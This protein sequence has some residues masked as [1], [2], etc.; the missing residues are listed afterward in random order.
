M[1]TT[2][3]SLLFR[4]IYSLKFQRVCPSEEAAFTTLGSIAL[5]G[6]R[7]AI[8]QLGETFLVIGLGLLG[9]IAVQLLRACGCNVIG[10]DLDESLTG[11]IQTYGATGVPISQSAARACLDF[12]QGRGVDGVII[13]AGTSS[14]DPIELAGDVT[15]EKGRVVVVGAVGMNVPREPYFKKEINLCI[16][17]SYGPGR[18]DPNYE[19]KGNDYPLGYVRF[20]EQRNMESFL[21]LVADNKINISG[22]I[23]H[24]FPLEEAAKAYQLIEGEKVEPYLGIVVQYALKSQVDDTTK[25]RIEVNPRP[26]GSGKIAVS[27]L[28]A[29]NYATASLLP[30]LKEYDG[31]SLHGLATLSGRTAKG[32]AQQFGFGFCANDLNEIMADDTDAVM[33]ATRHNTHAEFVIQALRAGKHVYVEKPPSPFGG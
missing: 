33:I 26:V 5:Q 21:A 12:T 24:R 30:V 8:P 13:C 27:F 32:V 9:Q 20:T 17:R 29:G 14:N 31:V 3:N 28:G 11:R 10:T 7:L 2:Q 16:S 15:R 25:K 23:T 1:P 18:Y 6:V 4:R 19:E 22:L